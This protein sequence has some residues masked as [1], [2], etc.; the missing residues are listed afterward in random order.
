ML[1]LREAANID[2]REGGEGKEWTLLDCQGMEKAS[3]SHTKGHS[4]NVIA[5]LEKKKD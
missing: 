4:P 3:S 5:L 1:C 2:A